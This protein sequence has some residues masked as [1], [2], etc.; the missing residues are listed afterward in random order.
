ML[1]AYKYMDAERAKV[2]DN[3]PLHYNIKKADVALLGKAGAEVPFCT[4]QM[5]AKIYIQQHS[6]L[7]TNKVYDCI[8]NQ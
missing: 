2:M 5:F 7:Y 3:D 4:L 8:V 1:K 6:G